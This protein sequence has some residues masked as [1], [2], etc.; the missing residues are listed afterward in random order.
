MDVRRGLE[1]AHSRLL[2]SRSPQQAAMEFEEM[3]AI[4]SAAQVKSGGQTGESLR[5]RK[6]V[7]PFLLACIILTC[8]TA[9]G[10]N[11]VIGYQHRHPAAERVE[12]SV[13]A[14]GLRDLYDRE[15]PYL[16]SGMVLV[17]RK[18]RKFLL[19]IGA[20]GIIVSMVS[21]GLLFKTTEKLAV[22]CCV[23]A[24]RSLVEPNQE[25][26]LYADQRKQVSCWPLAVTMLVEVSRAIAHRSQS[27][28]PTE[29]HGRYQLCA[30]R[31]C[32]GRGRYA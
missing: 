7:I 14:L 29:F 27:S 23:S 24:V 8:N 9:A 2:K 11:S 5:Q 12:R 32:L 21:V 22:D 6:Y 13:C 18:S 26:R 3:A 10:V 31:R 19:V 25:M 17:D 16:Q 30:F 1:R 20:T 15:F 4:A 28:T